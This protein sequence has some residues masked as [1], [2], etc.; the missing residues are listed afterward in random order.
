MSCIPL[1]YVFIMFLEC[2]YEGQGFLADRK[3]QLP[4]ETYRNYDTETKCKVI[5]NLRKHL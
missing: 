4:F 5:F 3:G 2:I 1:P